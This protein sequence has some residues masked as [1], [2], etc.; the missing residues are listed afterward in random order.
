MLLLSFSGNNAA[1]VSSLNEAN[2]LQASHIVVV[3]FSL[4]FI[5][6]VNAWALAPHI[7]HVPRHHRPIIFLGSM[8]GPWVT[9]GPWVVDQSQSRTKVE[10]VIIS[11]ILHTKSK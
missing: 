5:K 3:L 1:I 9:K 7:H 4:A 10:C 11:L 2:L 8:F 6:D